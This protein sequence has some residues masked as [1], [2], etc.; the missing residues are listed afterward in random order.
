MAVKCGHCG[1]KHDTAGDV[2]KCS[3]G[4]A[5]AVQLATEAQRELIIKMCNE[6]GMDMSTEKYSVPDHLTRDDARATITA[7][8]NVP[9]PRA[10]NPMS[11]DEPGLFLLS[12]GVYKVVRSTAGKLYA[13]Q[14]EGTSWVY[15]P[16]VVRDLTEAHRMTV[17]QAQEYGVATGVCCM[18]GIELT[19]PESIALGIGPVCRTKF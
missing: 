19:N 8:K 7:L 4:F 11:I 9:V 12:G 1:G 16:G 17:E 5:P 14:L 18:C 10:S 13:K 6:R 3:N 2:R 15:A